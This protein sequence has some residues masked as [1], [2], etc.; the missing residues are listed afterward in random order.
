MKDRFDLEL[1]IARCIYDYHAFPTEHTYNNLKNEYKHY[2]NSNPIQD[3]RY[4]R[5]TKL[6][7][8]ITEHKIHEQL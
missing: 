2:I 8:Y 5:V 7:N 3:K 6:Y 1:R 4:E